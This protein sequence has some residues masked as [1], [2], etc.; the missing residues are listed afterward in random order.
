[1]NRYTFRGF[2]LLSLTNWFLASVFDVLLV[3]MIDDETGIIKFF[4]QDR[5]FYPNEK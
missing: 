3:R 4:L 2:S 5:K 1:M